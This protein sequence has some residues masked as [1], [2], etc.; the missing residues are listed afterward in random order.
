MDLPFQWDDGNYISP[1]VASSEAYLA[2]AS[3]WLLEN[4]LLTALA[5]HA[6]AISCPSTSPVTTIPLTLVFELV[7]LGC[8]DG[9]A[10]FF[11]ARHL[12]ALWDERAQRVTANARRGGDDALESVIARTR[13]RIIATGIDLDEELIVKA[14]A[15]AAAAAA[16]APPPTAATEYVFICEDLQSSDSDAL[17]RPYARSSSSDDGAGTVTVRAH[18]VLYLYL[19]PEGLEAI[20]AAVVDVA[21]PRDWIVISNRWPIPYLDAVCTQERVDPLTIYRRSDDTMEQPVEETA[22]AT[23]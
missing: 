13:L 3:D 1:F 15:A 8:G 19:I 14:K 2:T 22:E 9:S 16:P 5:R 11:I 23:P 6:A 4:S 20:K 18:P 17:F 7:D 21:G 10:L 12:A